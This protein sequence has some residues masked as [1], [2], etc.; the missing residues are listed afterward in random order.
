MTFRAWREILNKAL[1]MKGSYC[2][3]IEWFLF[4]QLSELVLT[5]TVLTLLGLR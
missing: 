1:N 5:M 2:T 4:E 3:G